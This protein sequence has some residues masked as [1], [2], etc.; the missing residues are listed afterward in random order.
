MPVEWTRILVF[1]RFKSCAW[2][3]NVVETTKMN[4]RELTVS[5]FYAQTN[6]CIYKQSLLHFKATSH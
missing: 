2:S 1:H 3:A 5:I 4:V 6:I